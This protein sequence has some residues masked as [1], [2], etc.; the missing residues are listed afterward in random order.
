MQRQAPSPAV[1]PASGPAPFQALLEL[2][3]I[4]RHHTSCISAGCS[5]A[6]WGQGKGSDSRR[7]R[8]EGPSVKPG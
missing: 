4:T 1:T 7:W 8:P 6:V 3:K 5:L 2:F